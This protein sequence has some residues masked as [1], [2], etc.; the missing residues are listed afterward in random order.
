MIRGAGWNL[1]TRFMLFGRG[2]GLE[3]FEN[4]HCNISALTF[5]FH[6]TGDT[7]VRRGKLFLKD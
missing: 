6:R 3:D 7:A 4:F 2:E 1:V 5:I